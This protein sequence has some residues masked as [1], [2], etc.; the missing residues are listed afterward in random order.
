[1]PIT[2]YGSEDE[3][4]TMCIENT[5]IT[6]REGADLRALVHAAGFERITL[7]DVKVTDFAGD[8]LVRT[9]SDGEVV[10]KNVEAGDAVTKKPAEE[11]F[12]ARPI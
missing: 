6:I 11:A 3:P 9:W 10:V 8:C 7:R 1:M 4:L 12:S 2:A 5:S